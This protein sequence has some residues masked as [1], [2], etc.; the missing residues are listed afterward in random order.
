[1]KT[2][3][4]I[5]ARYRS[6]RFPGKLLEDLEG[7]SVLARTIERCQGSK[8]VDRVLVATDDERI[9]EEARACGEE[10]VMTSSGHNSG[11]E[12][13]AEAYRRM[14]EDPDIV[15]DVQG[16]EP[17]I[18]PEQIDRLIELLEEPSVNIATLACPIE[19]EK[20]FKDPDR[21]KLVAAPE[22]RCLYFSRSPIPFIRNED[23][24]SRLQ[25]IGVYGFR[26][27]LLPELAELS[28]TPL[29][30]SEGLEQLRWLEHGHRID[31]AVTKA[32]HP[33]IDNPND[34]ERAKARIKEEG[35]KDVRTGNG[36]A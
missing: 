21:V 25:H 24:A 27:P 35:E 14:S 26:A 1:M 8:K 32:H 18:L 2:L 30:R 6:T 3:V 29:E 34:L 10:G 19:E 16:D 20:A 5:P 9:L 11:T 12:R 7:K 15:I 28:S 13:S 17:F 31:V 22:G 33:G 36:S 23:R 4:I